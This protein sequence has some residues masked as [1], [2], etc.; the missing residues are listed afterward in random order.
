LE[1]E[2]AGGGGAAVLE[3][4]EAGGDAGDVEGLVGAEGPV[5]VGDGEPVEVHAEQPVVELAGPPGHPGKLAA[6]EWRYLGAHAE[7]VARQPVGHA[8]ADEPFDG[9]PR[10]PGACD[11]WAQAERL[12]EL[13][14]VNDRWFAFAPQDGSKRRRTSNAEGPMTPAQTCST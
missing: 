7:F 4:V 11:R 5:G 13:A 14:Q 3:V 10:P 2:A 1:A 12:A 6:R 8:E 9:P